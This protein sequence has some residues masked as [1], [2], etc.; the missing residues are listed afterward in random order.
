[1]ECRAGLSRL[2]AGELDQLGPLRNVLGEKVTELG[3]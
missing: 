3:R 1:M 2:E